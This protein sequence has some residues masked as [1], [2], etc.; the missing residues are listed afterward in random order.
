MLF[1][2]SKTSFK[3]LSAYPVSIFLG[4]GIISLF[5]R[6]S[7]LDYVLILLRMQFEEWDIHLGKVPYVAL[8]L[9][10]YPGLMK[11]SIYLRIFA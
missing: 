11:M 10:L 4:C 2:E 5:S 3:V 8:I 1:D 7:F 6:G 9:V